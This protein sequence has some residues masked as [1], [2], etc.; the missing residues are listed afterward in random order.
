MLRSRVQRSLERGHRPEK[1]VDA[2]GLAHTDPK[3]RFAVLAALLPH[4]VRL[5][6][7][8]FDVSELAE[9]SRT[10]AFRGLYPFV[11]AIAAYPAGTA[12]DNALYSGMPGWGFAQVAGLLRR[13]PVLRSLREAWEARAARRF[14][15]AFLDGVVVPCRFSLVALDGDWQLLSSHAAGGP[16]AGRFFAPDLESKTQGMIGY[17]SRIPAVVLREGAFGST[18]MR[19][20][21]LDE[22]GQPRVITEGRLVEGLYTN[23]AFIAGVGSVPSTNPTS[24]AGA[25]SLVVGPPLWYRDTQGRLVLAVSGLFTFAEAIGKGVLG[26]ALHLLGIGAGRLAGGGRFA[27][28]APEHQI[29]LTEGE[30][31]DI[32]FLDPERQPRCVPTQVSGDPFQAATMTVRVAWGPLPILSAP[33]S[34]LLAAAQRALTRLRHLQGRTL[35]TVYIGGVPFFRQ[36]TGRQRPAELPMPPWTLPRRLDR[37]QTSWVARLG[38]IGVGPFIDTTEQGLALGRRGRHAHDSDQTTHLVLRRERGTLMVRV[39]RSRPH[40][41]VFESRTSYRPGWGGW[42]VHEH[43]VRRYDADQAPV[44][45]FEEH[46]FREADSVRPAAPDFFRGGHEP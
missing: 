27:A 17:L 39:V 36:R 26:R 19:I 15:D 21:A 28:A 23:R 18:L 43:E 13:L 7:H 44:L 30:S 16:A 37:A 42:I 38:Q 2:V 45:V 14:V 3:L 35:D 6:A 33:D 34:L 31:V 25:S 32:A 29:T 4:R 10:A 12:S 20:R 41:A 8:G 1:V 11:R 9:Q 24:Y 22:G 40:G 46:Y 5:R